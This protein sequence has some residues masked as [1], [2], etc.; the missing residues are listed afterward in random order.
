MSLSLPKS[1]VDS[2]YFRTCGDKWL[3][4]GWYPFH[5]SKTPENNMF[6]SLTLTL[7]KICNRQIFDRKV[8]KKE[9]LFLKL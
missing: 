8:T 5:K 3:F 7:G 1:I 9:R 2:H 6:N 4:T